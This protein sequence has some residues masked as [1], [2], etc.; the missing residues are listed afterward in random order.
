MADNYSG[1]YVLSF[2]LE[3]LA[4]VGEEGTLSSSL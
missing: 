3:S 4:G 2:L 1:C